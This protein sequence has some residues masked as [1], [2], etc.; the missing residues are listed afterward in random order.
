MDHFLVRTP[1]HLGDGV[2]ALPA[3]HAI[4][5]VGTVH[6]VGPPWAE[7]LYASI[8]CTPSASPDA[9]VLFKPSFSAAWN[10]RHVSRRIGHNGHWRKWLLTEPLPP[11]DGHRTEGYAAIARAVNAN[12]QGPPSFTTTPEEQREALR[13]VSD[14]SVLLLPL[15]KSQ[16]TVG[17]PGFRALADAIG[18]RAVFAAGPG[19]CEQ[20]RLIAGP[21]QMLPPLDIGVFGAAAQRVAHVVGNDSGLTQLA[22]AARHSIECDP[23]TVHVVFGSTS[24]DGTGPIGCT[25]HQT[26]PL[27]CQPCYKKHCTIAA[28]PPCLNVGIES[29]QE[30]IV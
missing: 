12:V 7:R 3:I 5:R 27:P 18:P 30:A 20:L 10:V 2:M 1:D 6:L 29:I 9:A 22:A 16:R 17:W 8:D 26:A 14:Q 11:S 28:Q 15:S 13:L 24:P 25:P 23:T 4:A 19:E 21:H